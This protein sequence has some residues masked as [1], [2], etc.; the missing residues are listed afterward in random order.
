[1]RSLRNDT[2]SRNVYEG[3]HQARLELEFQR[4]SY[5]KSVLSY[6]ADGRAWLERDQSIHT[7]VAHY[8]RSRGGG[9]ETVRYVWNSIES[10]TY[11]HTGVALNAYLVARDVMTEIGYPLVGEETEEEEV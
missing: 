2:K 4:E 7:Q 9:L 3:M 6:G 8:V 10:L 11:D 5:R 1:M